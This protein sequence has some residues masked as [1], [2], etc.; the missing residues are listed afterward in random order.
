MMSEYRNSPSFHKPGNFPGRRS[1]YFKL[2]NSDTSG[3]T[4]SKQG[5]FNAFSSGHSRQKVLTERSGLVS[6]RTNVPW[7]HP[8][9][10]VSRIAFRFNILGKWVNWENA[11]TR[12][13]TR[14]EDSPSFQ[15]S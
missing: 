15:S 10:R 5:S 12:S 3:R 11:P 14:R 1:S 7:T 13:L 8:S 9:R 4:T 2:N 6:L